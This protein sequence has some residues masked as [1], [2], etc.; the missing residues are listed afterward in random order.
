MQRSNLFLISLVCTAF[1]FYS[2]AVV[3]LDKELSLVSSNDSSS[4][5]TGIAGDSVSVNVVIDN[6]SVVAGAALTVLYDT[7]NLSLTEISSLFFGTFTSQGIPTPDDQGYVTIDGEDYNG[8]IVSNTVSDLVGASATGTLIAAARVDDGSGINA[9]LFTLTFQLIGVPGTYDMSI[10][11]SKISNVSAGYDVNGELIPY[12][13]GVGDAV[14]P[15]P[16]HQVPVTN[17]C[18]IVVQADPVTDHD[19]D[20][21]DIDDDWEK[22]N[23]P[24][25]TESGQELNVFTA[26]GDYDGDGYSDYQEFLNKDISDPMDASF[27]P[28]LANAPGGVGYKS[29]SSFLLMIL[30][31]ILSAGRE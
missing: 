12:L 11:Q 14:D 29:K 15:Y 16:S 18:S 31:S 30:P 6:A 5:V 17:G 25:G 26:S 7:A 10:T 19:T 13:V 9:V 24:D 28:T 20:N 3:A 23:V 27:D 22:A 2:T 1:L 4:T 21:D 8:P